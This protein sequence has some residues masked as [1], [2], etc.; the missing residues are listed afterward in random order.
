[1]PCGRCQGGGCD[2]C[3]RRG[4]F[5]QIASGI[6]SEL[7]VTL[8]RQGQGPRS[9]VCL[10]LPDSGASAPAESELPRGHLLLTVVPREPTPGWV[11]ASSIVVLHLP[12][13]RSKWLRPPLLWFWA[14]ALGLAI[15][16]CIGRRLAG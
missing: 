15:L 6:P 4:A 7:A 14:V 3:E 11:P 10:R 5:E 12:V 8:P 1:L 16:I 13:T 2:G 9:A